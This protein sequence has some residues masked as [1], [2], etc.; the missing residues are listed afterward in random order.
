MIRVPYYK[1]TTASGATVET[2]L[3]SLHGPGFLRVS[4]PISVCELLESDELSTLSVECRGRG[5]KVKH[6]EFTRIKG[7]TFVEG[8]G[9]WAV[10]AQ[11]LRC[12]N[13]HGETCTAYLQVDA[14]PSGGVFVTA[15][16]KVYNPGMPPTLVQLDVEF[17]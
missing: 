14:D 10:G 13:D 15:Y 17:D 3:S 8:T 5:L 1:V 11:E 16:A 12:A 6:S 2:H 9:A 4:K 7:K